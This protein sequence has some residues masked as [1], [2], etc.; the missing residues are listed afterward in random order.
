MSRRTG[1]MYLNPLAE[2]DPAAIMS[3][4]LVQLLPQSLWWK[5]VGAAQS[6]ISTLQW[7]PTLACLAAT[8]AVT[9]RDTQHNGNGSSL[10]CPSKHASSQQ[11]LQPLPKQSTLVHNNATFSP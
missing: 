6:F 3:Q 2:R 1:S 5:H 10:F 8:P 11:P 7:S 9:L 4:P